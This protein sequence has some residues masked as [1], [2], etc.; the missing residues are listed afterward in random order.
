[1]HRHYTRL[2]PDEQWLEAILDAAKAWYAHLQ[3]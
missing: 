3:V 1:M 2:R